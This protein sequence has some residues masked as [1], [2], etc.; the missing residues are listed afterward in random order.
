V[1]LARID[2]HEARVLI[3]TGA[4]APIISSSWLGVTDAQ[5]V[6]THELCF[7]EL[8]LRGEQ[9]YAEDSQFSQPDAASINGFIG[10]RTL[11]HFIVEFDHENGVRFTQGASA[12]TG[13]SHAITFGAEGTPFA[14]VSV[15]GHDF[16]S[17]TIDSGSTY[18]LF[19][20]AS[21]SQ[22]E[23]YVSD[24]SQ[25]ADLCTIN[26]CMTGVA[27]TSTVNE[28]CVFGACQ[29]RVPVKFPAF[30]AVGSSWLFLRDTAFDFPGSS[31]VFCE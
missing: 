31:I 25:V 23:A 18:T 7:G 13:A 30:D 6:R 15:D 29:E 28:Y 5:W 1:I 8:C 14:D 4:Q 26:G 2:G 16:P 21:L 27:R 3:D 19:S 17:V 9:V 11:R 20:Q 22:L 24:G 12:C 10:M